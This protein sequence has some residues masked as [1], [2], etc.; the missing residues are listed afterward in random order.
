MQS[1]NS[2]GYSVSATN[3]YP[4]ELFSSV[5]FTSN[6]SISIWFNHLNSP[7]GKYWLIAQ[8]YKLF[9]SRYV[10]YVLDFLSL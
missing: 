4:F 2:S 5:E 3:M 9:A 7:Y 6:S 10:I 8:P 1:C